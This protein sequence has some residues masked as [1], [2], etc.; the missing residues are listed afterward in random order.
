MEKKFKLGDIVKI[1]TLIMSDGRILLGNIGH[2][3]MI[4]GID[5]YDTHGGYTYY[6]LDP[7]C[8]G[9]CWPAECL[10]MVKPAEP[11]KPVK[12]TGTLFSIDD[13]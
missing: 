13:L 8:R 5:D 7:Y 9:K 10:Q 12:I 2:E 11:D 6:E 4:I 3:G 1:K